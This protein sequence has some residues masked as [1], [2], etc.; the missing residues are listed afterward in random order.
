[1][2]A[3]L[4]PRGRVARSVVAAR[5]C[6]TCRDPAGRGQ[7]SGGVRPAREPRREPSHSRVPLFDLSTPTRQAALA[8]A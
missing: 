2:E 8:A 5:P 6:P 1:M 4:L 7:H 3:L